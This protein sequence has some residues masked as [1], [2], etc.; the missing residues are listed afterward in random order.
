[1]NISAR[2]QAHHGLGR[3]TMK[4][5]TFAL[6]AAMAGALYGVPAWAQQPIKAAPGYASGYYQVAEVNQPSPSDA[7]GGEN[8]VRVSRC[9]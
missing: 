9:H 6:A 8:R 2:N 5:S 7:A 3:N 4:W 1:M